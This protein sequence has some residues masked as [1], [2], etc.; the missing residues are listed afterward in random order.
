M[1]NPWEIGLALVV[2]LVI[3]GPSKLPGIGQSLGKAIK[4]F[5]HS[6]DDNPQATEEAPPA[7]AA[8]IEDQTPP[9]QAASTS[10]TTQTK[11]N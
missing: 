5:K 9:T 1:L 10:Q 2:V 3:F 8:K 4:N 7:Q 6:I 11:V